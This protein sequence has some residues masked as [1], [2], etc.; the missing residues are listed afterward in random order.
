MKRFLSLL[1]IG[2]VACLTG[3]GGGEDE[4][5]AA[6]AAEAAAETGAAAAETA[7][8]ETPPAELPPVAAGNAADVDAAM[9]QR[10]YVRAADLLIQQSLSR[11]PG[12]E[13]DSMV[14]MRQLQV[15]MADAIASGDPRAI[16]AAE[17]LRRVGR[18]PR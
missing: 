14:R 2:T 1:L 15:Q 5:A 11:Q 6:P 7:A 9:Q 10:D 3:C 8:A 17:L 12:E 4:D 13:D 16:Q 18:M